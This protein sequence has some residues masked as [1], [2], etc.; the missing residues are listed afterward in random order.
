MGLT[1]SSASVVQGS[2][3]A[4]RF[5]PIALF[6][7]NRPEHTQRT[8]DSLRENEIAA[9]SDL[10]V[11]S[12]GA[13]NEAGA[14]RVQQV[15]QY[16]RGLDGF[17]SVTI[18]E[19]DRN[20]GL[21][22]SVIS[23]VTQLCQEYGR[24][25][26]VEDDLLTAPD[27]LTFMN[28][29]LER[30]EDE[31]RILSV[32]GFNF[33]LKPPTNYAYDVFYS[34]RSSSW[35]WGT[36]SDRWEGADWNVSDYGAFRVDSRQQHLFNRGG[37]DLSRFLELQMTG[38]VD[39]WAIRWAYTHFKQNA[40][41]VLP[42]ASKVYNIGFDGSGVHCSFRSAPQ[43]AL[44]HGKNSEYRFPNSTEPD[45]YFIAEVQ[46]MCR[47]SLPRKLANFVHTKWLESRGGDG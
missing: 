13:K 46:R 9:Q 37:E 34:Y 36:W 27:F 6:V 25:I 33:A 23:G 47:R 35:G 28:S 26:V 24:V 15:R 20:L 41:A 31:P 3:R 40:V 29:A 18:V 12:D 14:A 7:Y 4:G 43:T 42:I 19:R 11:F 30:Y 17:R 38:K 32:S 8:V 39:S 21:A 1:S 10:F 44:A 5:A 22:N 16:V 45:P 2:H